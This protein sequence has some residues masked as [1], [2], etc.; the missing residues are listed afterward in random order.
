MLFNLKQHAF[1]VCPFTMVL[2]R[3]SHSLRGPG[4]PCE[5]RSGSDQ[6]AQRT[7]ALSR[8]VWH[9]CP[10]VFALGLQA[11]YTVLVSGK[12]GLQTD[13]MFIWGWIWGADGNNR[14][15]GLSMLPL[16]ATPGTPFC[17]GT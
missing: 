4:R 10:V 3:R 17:Q 8:G 2:G 16:G 12:L 1:L 7:W 15:P 14:G 9:P 11:D 5:G 13:Y 6:R